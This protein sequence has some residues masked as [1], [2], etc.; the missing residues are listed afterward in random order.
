MSVDKECPLT[1]QVDRLFAPFGNVALADGLGE[2]GLGYE[3]DPADMNSH[4]EQS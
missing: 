3:S 4:F 1:V 2:L